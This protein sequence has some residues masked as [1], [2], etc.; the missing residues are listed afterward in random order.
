MNKTILIKS[1]VNENPRNRILIST[2]TL[3]VIRYEWAA[4]RFGQVIPCNWSSTST[5]T[6]IGNIVPMH[7]LVADAQNLSVQHALQN[8]FEWLL[9]W[10]DDVLPPIDVFLRL[11]EYI[12]KATIPIVSGLYFTKGEYS[13]PVLYRGRGN[14][15]FSD[16][17]MG[18][19]VWVDGVPTGLLLIHSSILK[20]MW[21]ESEEYTTLGKL[22]T[23]QVF[24]SPSD[25]FYDPQTHD[26]RVVMGTSDLQWC[27]RIIKEKVL[28][29]A[30]WTKIAK[31]KH[32]FLCDTRIFCQH[33][34]LNTGKQ[35]PTQLPAPWIKEIKQAQL[36]E[37]R[38]SLKDPRKRRFAEQIKI[39]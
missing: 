14:G 20:V 4:V 13:E 12:K 24:D 35:Y 17:K 8:N 6:G 15:C 27:M 3:G 25:T 5:S 19:K 21:Q 31:K 37:I 26:P 9:L 36:K 33:I 2:P 16:F 23:R 28:E 38:A 1:G 10:E 22:K 39:G 29:K 18:E 11:N 34:D 32:P 7:Y 30:G